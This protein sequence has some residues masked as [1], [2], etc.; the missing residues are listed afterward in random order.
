[1]LH[2]ANPTHHHIYHTCTLDHLQY[3]TGVTFPQHPL[4]WSFVVGTSAAHPALPAL[5][6]CAFPNPKL[7]NTRPTC[8]CCHSLRI[9]PPIV[10][11]ALSCLRNLRLLIDFQLL[12]LG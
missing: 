11:C 2:D 12:N 3:T 7:D 1:M 5:R 9:V 8:P 4:S 6:R 10:L